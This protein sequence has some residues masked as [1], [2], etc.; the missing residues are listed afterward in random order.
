MTNPT[1]RPS[2]TTPPGAPGDEPGRVV[3][4]PRAREPERPSHNLP[5]EL[6]SFVGRDR[7]VAEVKGLLADHRLLTLTGSGGCGK[8]RLALA[9]AFEALEGF[10]NG[11]WWVGL[12]P[13][14][15]PE[16]VPQAVARALSVPERPGLSF[17]EALADALREKRLLLVLDN[18]EHLIDACAG[19]ARAM[20]VSCPRLRGL[21]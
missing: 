5:V 12:A 20:L 17:T 9:A 18:C 7:E 15:D 2:D 11:A 6:T 16:L 13:L 8:S 14:S 3:A 19:F 21:R 10:E 1:H 4:F